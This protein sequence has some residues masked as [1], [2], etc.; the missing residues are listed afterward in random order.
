MRGAQ[1]TTVRPFVVPLP[2]G[3]AHTAVRAADKLVIVG[4][5]GT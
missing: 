3:F 1:Q 5:P 2:V 4:I